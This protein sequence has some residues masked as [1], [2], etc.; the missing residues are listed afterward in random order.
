MR[1]PVQTPPIHRSLLASAAHRTGGGIH[2]SQG[3]FGPGGPFGL[4]GPAGPFGPFGLFSSG[5]GPAPRI[6]VNTWVQCVP[7]DSDGGGCFHVHRAG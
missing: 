7:A 3:I 1:F 6:E 5:P 2:A 4:F